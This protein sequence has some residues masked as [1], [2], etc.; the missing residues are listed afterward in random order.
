MFHMDRITDEDYKKAFEQGQLI[1]LQ[2]VELK[3]LRRNFEKKATVALFKY[4][5]NL[6]NLSFSPLLGLI[7]GIEEAVSDCGPSAINLQKLEIS[8][9]ELS[10]NDITAVV[11][12]C[13]L[14]DPHLSN[15]FY[16]HYVN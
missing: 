2:R 10:K 16:V 6:T 14:R 7:G 3:G 11:S 13:N 1:S 9:C 12:L 8:S 15:T 4:C 5:P